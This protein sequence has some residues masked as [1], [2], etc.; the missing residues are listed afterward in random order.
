MEEIIMAEKAGV[1]ENE[2]LTSIED[3]DSFFMD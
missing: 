3:I 1:N 2:V